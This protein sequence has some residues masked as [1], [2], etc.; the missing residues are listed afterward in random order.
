M[1]SPTASQKQ[2]PDTRHRGKIDRLLNRLFRRHDLQPPAFTRL[3]AGIGLFWLGGAALA[4][5]LAPA[6]EPK[7]R[8]KLALLHSWSALFL[9]PSG[10][11]DLKSP[12]AWAIL[13]VVLLPV[14]LQLLAFGTAAK[15]ALYVVEAHKLARQQGRRH[16][17]SAL[18]T[19]AVKDG[20]PLGEY[21]GR[22]FG[23]TRGADAGH[24]LVVAP[25]RMGKGLH[26]TG[27]L[28]TWRG[29]AV[30]VDPKREQYQRTSGDR[31]SLGPIYC[32]P[33]HGVDILQ[34]YNINDTLDLQELFTTLLQ[35]WEDKD[36]IFSQKSYAIFE[37]AR[38]QSRATGEHMLKIL[39]RWADTSAP[40]AI[41]EGAQ[42]APGPIAKFTDGDMEELN[43]FTMSAWGTF[44]AK[45][46]TIAP[47][48]ATIS[49]ADIPTT[50]A[51]Q[52]ASIYIC[53]PLDQLEAAGG[54][55]S[56]ILS[57][58]IKGQ[59]RAL[60]KN[61][62]LF[63]VDE[64]RASRL[65]ALDTKL[66]TVGGYGITIMAY[67]QQ[68]S[69]LRDV[70]GNDAAASIIG[71]FHHQIFYPTRDNESA[72]YVSRKFGTEVQ[73]TRSYG[74][75]SASYAQQIGAALEPAMINTLPPTATIVFTDDLATAAQR[76]N[77]F[78]KRH[79][80]PLPPR[81]ITVRYAGGTTVYAADGRVIAR[82]KPKS[83][84]AV[85]A[86]NPPAVAET[87]EDEDIFF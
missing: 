26:L 39:A 6:L 29:A 84:A 22:R 37:A 74:G 49:R 28:E 24:V 62:T 81:E 52:G 67:L 64:L 31:A 38:D 53:Y 15:R 72:E 13:A 8:L 83:G 63:A 85:P 23:V 77:P 14:A 54:L 43:R 66:A 11:A 21:R 20:I 19:R 34:Y 87:E 79:A 60:K 25:T 78:T 16:P 70:Y 2:V 58:L 59:Q 47:H 40:V 50:W 41:K 76:V 68:L 36:P 65:H 61:Y 1:T 9:Q 30:I 5:L 73:T 80:P 33:Q 56:V 27:S 86:P 3:G 12:L 69:Q 4:Y 51:E 7:L 44:T 55:L 32:L 48:L 17:A 82:T 18:E 46:S 45:F 42:H 71:N 10:A 57:A 35:T 75:E